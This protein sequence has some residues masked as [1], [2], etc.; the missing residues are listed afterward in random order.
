[1]I[2]INHKVNKTRREGME[3]FVKSCFAVLVKN[4]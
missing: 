1:M 2:C 3:F 4:S